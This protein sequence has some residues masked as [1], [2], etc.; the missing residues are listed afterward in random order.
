MVRDNTTLLITASSALQ[1]VIDGKQPTF[2]VSGDDVSS[3]RLLRSNF[4][5]SVG[6]SDTVVPVLST[7]P[8]RTPLIKFNSTLNVG[9]LTGYAPTA[10]PSFTGTA[11][12]YDV[13]TITGLTRVNGTLKDLGLANYIALQLS[14]YA[15]L[16]NP[17]FTG[18]VSSNHFNAAT[19]LTIMGNT[20]A[21]ALQISN[22][23]TSFLTSAGATSLYPTKDAVSNTFT[24]Y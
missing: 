20:V 21:S 12:F 15:P 8:D 11:N 19:S 18:T 6:S 1:T 4:L 16:Q 17:K 3:F 14:I 22:T 5:A 23:L 24:S 9:S 10:N 2:T 7:N 13:T